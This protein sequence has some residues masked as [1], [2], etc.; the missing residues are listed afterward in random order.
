MVQ[1]LL[2]SGIR[3]QGDWAFTLLSGSQSIIFKGAEEDAQVLSTVVLSVAGP[4]FR[5]GGVSEQNC[6]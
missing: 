6:A 4:A 2:C 3:G 1:G 5:D